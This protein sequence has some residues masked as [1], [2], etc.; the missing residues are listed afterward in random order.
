MT[1]GIALLVYASVGTSAAPAWPGATVVSALGDVWYTAPFVIGLV[2]IPLLFPDG[3]LPS[4]RFRW[5]VRATVAGMVS[6]A[7]AGLA[8][9]APGVAGVDAIAGAL[10]AL[11]VG[12]IVFGIGGAG[13]AIAVQFRRGDPVQRQQLK[14][15]LAD[16]AV[17]VLAFPV[18]MVLG[19]S[20]SWWTLR[21]G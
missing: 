2:G 17:A 14:W 21:P 15:L 12:S 13:T 10:V 16:A 9:L 7:L 11:S 5:V 19:S 20:D 1:A 6:M 8:R 3:R 4:R 18:A